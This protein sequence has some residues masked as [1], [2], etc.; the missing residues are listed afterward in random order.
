VYNPNQIS[1]ENLHMGSQW[2]RL[3]SSR[4]KPSNQAYETAAATFLGRIMHI[5]E[6]N[7]HQITRLC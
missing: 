6:R 2:Y 1:K 4:A 5:R 7:N 3:E